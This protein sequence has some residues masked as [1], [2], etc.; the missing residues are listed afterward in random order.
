LG[1]VKTHGKYS[2]STDGGSWHLS[3]VWRFLNLNHHVQSFLFWE[4]HH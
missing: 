3:Q 2:V 1:L 4:K